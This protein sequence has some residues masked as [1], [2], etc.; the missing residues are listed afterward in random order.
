M[1]KLI[2]QILLVGMQTWN[3]ERRRHFQKKHLKAL[4]RLDQASNAQGEKYND[5]ELYLADQELKN[6]YEAYLAES[7][8][9]NRESIG[10][11]Q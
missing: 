11:D 8:A 6:F 10:G 3:E 7:Q 5:D 9:H 1:G 2:A 4:Q